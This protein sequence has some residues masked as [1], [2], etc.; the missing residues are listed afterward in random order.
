M[1]SYHPDP[2]VDAIL[3]Q[4]RDE[5]VY[6]AIHRARLVHRTEPVEVFLFG[7][8]VL[9]LPVDRVA[10]WDEVMP[11]RV[12]VMAARGATRGMVPLSFPEM[13]RLHP[14]LFATAEAARSNVRREVAASNME[15]SALKAV[16]LLINIS[17]Y[18]SSTVIRRLRYRLPLAP[19]GQRATTHEAL[20]AC[21]T[22]AGQDAKAWL[23][24]LLGADAHW[25]E[26]EGAVIV[27]GGLAAGPVVTVVEVPVVSG[28]P[29]PA[30]QV[31]PQAPVAALDSPSP[32]VADPPADL[33]VTPTPTLASIPFMAPMELGGRAAKVAMAP[34]TMPLSG[35]ASVRACGTSPDADEPSFDEKD[36]ADSFMGRAGITPGRLRIFMDRG[37]VRRRL[38]GQPVRRARVLALGMM[39]PVEFQAF[40]AELK[41][42]TPPCT[43]AP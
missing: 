6:Q 31:V 42:D 17:P 19:G 25:A 12:E 13:A 3:R 39:R 28:V 29:L 38:V 36:L 22:L 41:K 7:R 14:N 27:K 33:V 40:V 23:D 37:E 20:V 30:A 43:P 26:L 32:P 5:E 9:S 35:P 15:T 21:P 1:V 18:R 4:I 24:G 8:S 16:E 34:A 11:N 2:R 10:S